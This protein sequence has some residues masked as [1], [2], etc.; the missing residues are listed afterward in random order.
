ME[1]S[2]SHDSEMVQHLYIGCSEGWVPAG[3]HLTPCWYPRTFL[4]PTLPGF[5]YTSVAPF[6][7]RGTKSIPFLKRKWVILGAKKWLMGHL[8]LE[9][10]K[11]WP[12]VTWGGAPK[13]IFFDGNALSESI[14]STYQLPSLQI[15][16]IPT[17]GQPNVKCLM[18]MESKYYRIIQIVNVD[19]YNCINSKHLFASKH[20]TSK[21]FTIFCLITF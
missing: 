1:C 13:K 16:Q 18:E 8:L 21:L 9:H 3:G 19:C 11:G 15:D 5:Q 2:R 20:H 6:W 17:L 10:L 7:N 14:H 12:L 4:V